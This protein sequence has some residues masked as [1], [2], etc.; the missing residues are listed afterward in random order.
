[1]CVGAMDIS[2][3]GPQRLASKP[4]EARLYAWNDLG[5]PTYDGAKAKR[6]A[7]YLQAATPQ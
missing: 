6:V 7:L 1:M 3:H 2:T 4:M 5:T